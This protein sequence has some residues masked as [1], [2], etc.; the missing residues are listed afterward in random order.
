M[1]QCELELKQN[2]FEIYYAETEPD[3]PIRASANGKVSGIFTVR[4]PILMGEPWILDGYIL[5]HA[6]KENVITSSI[7]E[8]IKHHYE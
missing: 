3:R 2:G 5:Y 1:A 7:D 8:L 6:K 4:N